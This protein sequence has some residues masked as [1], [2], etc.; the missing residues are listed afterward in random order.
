MNT[1]SKHI[2]LSDLFA[3]YLNNNEDGAW[4]FGGKLN[5]RP[6]YQREFV[7]NEK[8]QKAVIK[9][10]LKGA[11]LNLIYW[12]K[13]D[14]DTFELLDGQQRTLSICKFLNNDFS[15]KINDVERY[16]FQLEKTELGKTILDYQLFVCQCSGTREEKLEW[17]ETINTDGE[18]LNKQELLNAI[19]GS[20]WLTDARKKF[21][22]NNCPA[23][24]IGKDFLKGSSIR[25]DYL[26]TVLK[27]IS[28]GKIQ[29]FLAEKQHADAD[30]SDL[31][32][33]F[34]SIINWI[35]AVFSVNPRPNLMKGVDWGPLF[36]KYGQTYYDAKKIEAKLS[37]LIDNE[38]IVTSPKIYKYIF[39]EDRR[40]L[41]SRTFKKSEKMD[42]YEKQGRK[43]SCGQEF[44]FE[45]LEGDHV[46][47]WSKGGETVKSNLQ[48]LC[49]ECNR[50]KSAK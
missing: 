11:P 23:S 35:N 28:K 24:Q 21:S 19:Y 12:A 20:P 22:K 44:A 31:F 8:Q 7:Y 37:A 49:K 1:E 47:A 41:Q 2:K 46:I 40:D 25:Q 26:A 30:A 29:A 34:E 27:W 5:V 45:D 16:F 39:T 36:E 15:V 9:T 17:F 18:K 3:G 14:D 4:A 42:L 43:C 10:I 13:N 48:L 6:R 50:R 33:Y 38:D 32:E